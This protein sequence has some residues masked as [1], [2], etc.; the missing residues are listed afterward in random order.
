MAKV[1]AR[2]ANFSYIVSFSW[3]LLFVLAGRSY[4]DI[5]LVDLQTTV[6][7]DSLVVSWKNNIS[8]DNVYATVTVA[9]VAQVCEKTDNCNLAF[10]GLTP[11]TNYKYA[12]KLVDISDNS[13]L[14]ETSNVNTMPLL[15]IN[16]ISVDPSQTSVA[17]T[18]QNQ[19][20]DKDSSALISS[21]TINGLS[22]QCNATKDCAGTI[23]NLHPNIAY[24]YTLSATDLNANVSYSTSGTVK[25]LAYPP[26]SV[27][28]KDL[29]ERCSGSSCTDVIEYS[30]T[31]GK[32]PYVVHLSSA[33]PAVISEHE[34]SNT[35]WIVQLQ[36]DTTY[37]LKFVATDAVGAL[38]SG[39]IKIVSGE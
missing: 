28:L 24:L 8:A 36:L 21:V 15:A 17:F 26:L 20:A 10:T 3:L 34:Y 38:G 29:D 22:V 33:D 31:G 35:Q 25:T 37:N 19:F 4:A 12:I 14:L 30:V 1:I 6:T 27:G 11:G 5:N 39:Q 9:G 18:W 16:G 7:P 13:Q 2:C 23:N 32:P